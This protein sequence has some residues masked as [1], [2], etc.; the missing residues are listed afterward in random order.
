MTHP[1]GRRLIV[2][3]AG[4]VALATL[5]VGVTGVSLG[6]VPDGPPSSGRV[7][8]GSVPDGGPPPDQPPDPSAIDL[9]NLDKHPKMEGVIAATART[10]PLQGD[11]AA[12]DLARSR[13]VTVVGTAVR[14]VV[15]SVDPDPS[16]AHA[17]VVAAGG[18]VEAE[19]ADAIQTLLP[20]SALEQVATD[21]TVRYIRAPAVGV[22]NTR[23][24]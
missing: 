15:E 7:P 1:R 19:Y 3:L 17:V 6:Q 21:P 14:V 24:P 12:L 13:G 16:A 10:A 22:P 4:L 5:L 18:V 9:T 20:P 23:A 8:E 11:G 2:M